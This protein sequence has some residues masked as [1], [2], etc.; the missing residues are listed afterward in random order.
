ME[1]ICRY[2]ERLTGADEV[3]VW[4]R[5][6]QILKPAG[7]DG[8]ANLDGDHPAALA[9]RTSRIAV[10]RI[11]EAAAIAVPILFHQ[12]PLGAMVFSRRGADFGSEEVVRAELLAGQAGFA[13]R[14]LRRARELELVYEVT[15]A[16]NS[17][18]TWNGAKIRRRVSACVSWP[19]DVHVSV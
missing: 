4:V 12:R 13:F 6:G 18:L 5:E 1:A 2:G 17:S 11:E 9:V 15:R 14:M 8:S 16:I 3:C 10:G 19:I 7:K